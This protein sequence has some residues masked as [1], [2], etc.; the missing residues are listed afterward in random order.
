M[1]RQPLRPLL[2]LVRTPPTPLVQM[3]GRQLAGGPGR[4]EEGVPQTFVFGDGH[5]EHGPRFRRDPRPSSGYNRTPAHLRVWAPRRG[6]CDRDGTCGCGW[7]GESGPRSRLHGFESRR[8]TYPKGDRH[9]FAPYV[10]LGQTPSRELSSRLLV[11]HQFAATRI[12]SRLFQHQPPKPPTATP[13][14]RDR[15]KYDRSALFPAAVSGP[16]VMAG[17]WPI[18]RRDTQYA[19]IHSALVEST[20]VCGIVLIGDA[21][22]GKTTLARLVTQSLPCRGAVGGRHRIGAQHPAGRV[23]P[24]GRVGDVPRP[25]RVPGGRARNHSRR[26]PFG[27]RR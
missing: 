1:T 25:G 9:R 14:R 18:L 10:G 8:G 6:R 3:T 21:G 13:T 27:D 2:E 22:V 7:S 17:N 15:K 23:R 16:V 26:R 12:G 24:P 20:G 19:T 11:P 5:L 4:P